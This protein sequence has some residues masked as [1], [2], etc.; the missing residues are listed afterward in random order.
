M[1]NSNHPAQQPNIAA[2][3]AKAR[4]DETDIYMSRYELSVKMYLADRYKSSVG[5]PQSS[6]Y[7]AG[8]EHR[9]LLD[10]ENDRSRQIRLVVSS[11]VG[12]ADLDDRAVTEETLTEKAYNEMP[13]KVQYLDRGSRMPPKVEY[14]R[15]MI[16]M[17]AKIE[18]VDRRDQIFTK[19]HKSNNSNHVIIQHG[20]S[21]GVKQPHWNSIGISH[22]KPSLTDQGLFHNGT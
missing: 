12:S 3:V 14:V 21:S 9:S 19:P 11:V 2:T 7:T 5:H 17:P 1:S 6:K 15:S 22:R 10:E 13:G 4:L 18:Y 16:Q 8:Q 20:H